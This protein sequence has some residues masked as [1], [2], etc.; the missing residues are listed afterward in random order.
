MNPVNS[1]SSILLTSDS[2]PWQHILSY[3]LYDN[4]HIL[5]HMIH[6]VT[7]YVVCICFQRVYPLR[8]KSWTKMIQRIAAERTATNQQQQQGMEKK[9]K[10]GAACGLMM[11]DQDLGVAFPT[12]IRRCCWPPWDSLGHNGDV[13]STYLPTLKR[14]TRWW[15]A[16]IRRF[17]DHLKRNGEGI[18]PVV[19]KDLD[20]PFL[21]V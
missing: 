8:K 14:Q 6:P 9:E 2:Q 15:K 19:V 11:I 4:P 7:C 5:S 3:A 17:L 12:Q 10:D 13:P 20:R 1:S 16:K 18:T 21:V